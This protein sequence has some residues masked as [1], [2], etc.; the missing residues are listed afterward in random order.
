MSSTPVPANFT[1]ILRLFPLP[2]RFLTAAPYGSGHINDTYVVHYD[3]GQP[4]P[5]RYVAQRI[6]HNIFKNVPALMENVQRVTAHLTAQT[7]PN[8]R[9]LALVLANDGRAVI[10]DEAGGWWR[11][12]D[13][14]EGA[15]TVDRVTNEAEAR[16]AAMAFGQFQ[17]QLADLPG[18]RL[19]ET[20]PNFHHTRSR[21]ENFRRAVQE[22]K[23]GRA[24]EVRADIDFAFTREADADVLLKLLAEGKV[25]ERVTHNDTK[26][27]NV[28]LDDATHRAVA[29]IDLD[30]VMPGLP[31]YDFGEM[32]RTSASSTA[33]DDPVAE[34]M[35][36]IV[37]YF[38]VLVNGYLD[39]A[40]GAVLN[41]TERAHLGFA[42][43]LMTYENGLRFLTDYLQGDTYYKIKHPRH[44]LDRCRTQFALVRSIEANQGEMNRILETLNT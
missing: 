44:N 23:A 32:M 33:E 6:N 39:S 43:K 42:G 28:M 15:H 31:L 26:I 34:N 27:N 8:S 1:E 22:D 30:T 4:A 38:R 18:G 10:Q 3:A 7:G 12:Y 19:Q 36:L 40:V 17:A 14:V 29:V 2:G 24:G 21:F 41:A 16:E 37:P 13:F 11:I 5:K 9:A 20:I 25:S 35:R